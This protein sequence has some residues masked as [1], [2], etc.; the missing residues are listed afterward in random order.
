MILSFNEIKQIRSALSANTDWA[1]DDFSAYMRNRFKALDGD[2]RIKMCAGE[3]G[4][5]ANALSPLL[6]TPNATI[7]NNTKQIIKK[8]T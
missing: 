5:I 7:Q 2:A 6:E 8:L 1:N 3:R 4:H